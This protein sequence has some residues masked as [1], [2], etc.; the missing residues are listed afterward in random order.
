MMAE[1]S[2]NVNLVLLLDTVEIIPIKHLDGSK[3]AFQ[4]IKVT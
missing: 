3:Q 4:V 1:L 2:G